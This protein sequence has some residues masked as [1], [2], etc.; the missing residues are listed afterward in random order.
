MDINA[1]KEELE[2]GGLKFVDSP[3]DTSQADGSAQNQDLGDGQAAQQD[4]G[5]V[6]AQVDAG[7][8]ARTQTADTNSSTT[9]TEAHD[10]S[11]RVTYTPPE[12]TGDDPATDNGYDNTEPTQEEVRSFVNSYLQESVGLTLEELAEKTQTQVD[13]RL[14]PILD[15]MEKTGR[16]P[17]DW[18]VYQQA[19]PANMDDVAVLRMQIMSEYPELSVA[20]VQMMVESKY[21]LDDELLEDRER[22]LLDLQL[23]MD[24][25][26]ARTEI[27]SMR[28]AYMI[29]KEGA[30]RQAQARPSGIANQEWIEQAYSEVEQLEGIDFEIGDKTFTFG[31]NNSTK[32]ML[33]SKN[34]QVDSYLDQYR[35]SDGDWDH[36]TFNVHQAVISNI[37]EIVKA[38]YNQGI[39]DGQRN[40]VQSAANVGTSSPTGGR[41]SDSVSKLEEQISQILGSNNQMMTIKF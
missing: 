31:L 26:K 38:V 9:D 33:K 12:P 37:D 29:P 27:S 10:D 25:K 19:D 17:Q 6:N 8:D 30:S 40:V 3:G 4:Q 5:A 36:E 41:S 34:A 28:E 22:R 11:T 15:F 23:K 16:D 24:A 20:D 1:I 13:E 21:K 32:G 2:A 35:T 7:E 18:F 39:S 14:K